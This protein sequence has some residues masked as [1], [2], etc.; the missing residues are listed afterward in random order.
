[1]NLQQFITDLRWVQRPEFNSSNVWFQ[2]ISIPPTD[3]SHCS[4][5]LQNEYELRNWVYIIY[6]IRVFNLFLLLYSIV[7]KRGKVVALEEEIQ[8][9]D[10]CHTLCHEGEMKF[11]N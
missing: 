11:T 2:K 5:L 9:N 1:M 6:L 8:G 10:L 3:S 4:L 7:K